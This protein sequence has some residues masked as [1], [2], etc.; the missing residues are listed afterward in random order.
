MSSV[1]LPSDTV[2]TDAEILAKNE[3]GTKLYRAEVFV[4]KGES[5]FKLV[6]LKKIYST[7]LNTY[8]LMFLLIL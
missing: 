6:I 4:L 5:D 2:F 7:Q 3:Q 8:T 1:D